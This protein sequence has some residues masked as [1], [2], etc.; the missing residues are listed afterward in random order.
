MSF[1]D[2]LKHPIKAALNLSLC[3]FCGV[4]QTDSG[5]CTTCLK[6]IE[7]TQR[8]CVRCGSLLT[9][10]EEATPSSHC[11]K[12]LQKSPAYQ[13]VIAAT[14]YTFPVDKAV[15]E[16]KFRKQLHYAR[17]LSQVLVHKIRN[18]YHDQPLPQAIVAIPLHSKRLQER[19]FNQSDI[20]AR[21]LSKELGIPQINA[22]VRIKNTPHQIGM[23]KKQRLKN[24]N[25]AFLLQHPL[26]PYIALVD[27]VV[28]TG[29]TVNE[30]AKLCLKQGVDRI[31]VWCL[32]KT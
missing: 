8:A 7:P 6:A 10:S 17:S 27:D 22:L 21:Q 9:E 20:I 1:F 25:N 32:A 12:C 11:G 4:A 19:G 30:A 24:L 28:T 26:P 2:S 14:R 5:I 29:A 18:Q 3:S 13:Q 31:D 16:L 23:S 15:G